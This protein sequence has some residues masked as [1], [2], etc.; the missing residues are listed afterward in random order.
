MRIGLTLLIAAALLTGAPRVQRTTIRIP[1][2][3]ESGAS[4]TAENL[5]AEAGGQPAK[6]VSLHGPSDD[7]M[8]LLVLD[9]VADLNEIDLARQA[10]AEAIRSLPRNVYIGVLRAQDG[11]RVLLDP[12]D[13]RDAILEAIQSAPVTGTPGLLETI[14]TVA[15]VGDAVLSKSSIRLAAMFITDSN[16]YAYREDFTNPVINYSDSRDLSRRFSDGLV[17]QRIAKLDEQ[18]SMSQTPVFV[19]HLEYDRDAL[20]EAASCSSFPPPPAALS[21]AARTRKSARRSRRRCRRPWGITGSTCRSRTAR[22][23]TST[24][25]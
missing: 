12:T 13:D 22:P 1:V 3:P 10:L 25:C 11:M 7:L 21:S 20:N 6:V 23:A 9:L 4:L 24:S 8:L 2:W 5:T 17:R 19:V 15:E 16:I 14:G 18:L